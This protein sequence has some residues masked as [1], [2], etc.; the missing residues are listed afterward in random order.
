MAKDKNVQVTAARAPEQTPENTYAPLVDIYETE[1][2]TVLAVEMPGVPKNDVHVE[3]DKGVLTIHG[4]TA[5]TAPGPQY[6]RTYVGFEPGEYFRAFALSDAVDRQRI[7][8][9]M[10]DGVL[11]VTLP[12]AEQARTHRI[13]IQGE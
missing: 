4:K 11:T 9:S 10:V 7:G 2:A 5:W 13:Q 12:K 3:V 1:D 6:S 8:A